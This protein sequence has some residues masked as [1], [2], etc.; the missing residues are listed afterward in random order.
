MASLLFKI[1]TFLFVLAAIIETIDAHGHVRKCYKSSIYA[2]I[3][4]S[5]GVDYDNLFTFM[6]QKIKDPS[7]EV[8]RKG[9]CDGK[10]YKISYR[11]PRVTQL[12]PLLIKTTPSPIT[13]MADKN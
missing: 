2:P 9:T 13:T 7:L 3:C 11:L 12:K 1:L 6:C 10:P 5:D 8:K 4:G